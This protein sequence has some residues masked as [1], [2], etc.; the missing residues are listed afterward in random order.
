MASQKKTPDP[1]ALAATGALAAAGAAAAAAG[2]VRATRRERERAFELAKDEE[3]APGV[4]RI[5]CGQLDDVA[6]HLD[7]NDDG[8]VHE[9]RKSFKRLR[10]LV[11]LTRDELGDEVR[12]RENAAFRDAGRQLSGARDAAVLVET[13]DSLDPEGFAGLRAALSEDDSVKPDEAAVRRAVEEARGRVE[14]WP[15]DGG[16]PA[17]LAPGLTRIFKRGRRAYEAAKREPSTEH[18]HELR[19]RAKDLWHAAQILHPA[20]PKRMRKLARDAHKL[21]DALGDDHDLAT[22]LE[23]ADHYQGAMTAEE[24]AR[25]TKLATRRRAKLQRNALRRARDLYATKPGKLAD[26]IS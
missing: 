12:Q 24:R 21:A 15:L 3:V 17:V 18:F 25:L 6:E 13:L 8:S 4:R 11:R 14:T 16:G 1:R 26:A 5:A 22:L 9:A 2:K 10:A 19:K 20:D 23:A 7:V